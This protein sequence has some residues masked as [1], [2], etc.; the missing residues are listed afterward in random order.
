[1]K[2][3]GT[4]SVAS[5]ISVLLAIAWPLVLIMSICGSAFFGP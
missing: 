3:F 2:Y 1:M 4:K 5:V